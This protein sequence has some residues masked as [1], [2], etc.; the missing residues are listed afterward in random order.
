[1]QF[2]LYVPGLLL[3]V[4]ILSNTVFDLSAPGL[5]LILGRGRRKALAPDWLASAFSL[6]SPLPAA[7]LRK[8]DPGSDIWLCLDP[9]HLRVARE[10][11]SLAEPARLDLGADESA[12]LLEAVQPLFA[13]LGELSASAP[14]RWELRLRRPLDLSTL[15]P[16]DAIDRPVD[17]SLP[18]GADGREFRHLLAEAQTVLHAHP[19]N[20]NRDALGK[21]TANSLWPWGQGSL[22]AAIRSDFSVVWSA[23][24]VVAGLCAHAGLPC[25]MPPS[26]FQ[27]ASG[28]VLALIDRLAPPAR[29]QDALGW[30]SALLAFERD[31]LVPAVAAIKDGSCTE[32]RVV[33]TRIHGAPATVEFSLCRG[34]LRYFW[35][36]P[37]PLTALA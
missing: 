30:R 5:S 9:V 36:R 2:T 19:I 21:P 13:E 31:W 3:P 11:I 24:P 28:R 34:E 25:L 8:T 7:A 37:K 18:G 23:N 22:P 6:T 20:R 33:G 15:P 32:L 17:P 16:Q 12:T 14:N 27:P 1:M 26:G 10:G 29:A 4:E 35:R